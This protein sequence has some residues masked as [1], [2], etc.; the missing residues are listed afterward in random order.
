MF[1][2]L[3]GEFA[4]S[5]MQAVAGL[6]IAQVILSVLQAFGRHCPW[7]LVLSNGHKDMLSS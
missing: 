2:R 1:S 4:C 6:C 7:K 3:R 5:L